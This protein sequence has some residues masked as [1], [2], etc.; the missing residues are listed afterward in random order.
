M[1]ENFRELVSEEERERERE[2]ERPAKSRGLLYSTISLSGADKTRERYP[3]SLAR[4]LVYAVS[5][6]V[7]TLFSL[8]SVVPVF[9]IFRTNI[10]RAKRVRK[11]HTERGRET[12]M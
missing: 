10:E 5:M 8:N 3:L 6:C 9:V 1:E 2:R 4:S 11:A 7:H 12:R